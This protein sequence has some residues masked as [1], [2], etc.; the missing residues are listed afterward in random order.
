MF[1]RSV[2]LPENQWLRLSIGALLVIG[3]L[4][5]FMPVLGIW[6]LPLGIAVLSIDVPIVR[7]YSRRFLRWFRR[8]YPETSAKVFPRNR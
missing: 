3:G 6:M 7:R 4:M 5:G 8:R 2:N 1:G